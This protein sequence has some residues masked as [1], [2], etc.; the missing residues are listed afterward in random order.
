[1]A[2]GGGGIV[3]LL[4]WKFSQQFLKLSLNILTKLCH[5]VGRFSGNIYTHLR[6]IIEPY[7]LNILTWCQWETFVKDTL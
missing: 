2:W 3:P 7:T 1:M 6:L 4:S 5:P